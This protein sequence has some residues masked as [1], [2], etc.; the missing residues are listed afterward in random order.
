L[1][2][3]NNKYFT[4]IRN[5]EN[6]EVSNSTFFHYKQHGD[7]I[8]ADYNGGEIVKGHLLGLK[9]NDK[10]VFVYHHINT[11]K[12]IRTGECNS[13]LKINSAGRIELHEE[14]EWTNGDLSKGN[15]IIE[16]VDIAEIN[17]NTYNYS[18]MNYHNKFKDYS[19]Y[20]NQIEKFAAYLNKDDELLDFGCGS[21]LNAE[22]FTRYGIK[23]TGVDM[24]K[25]MID[26][27]EKYSP[28]SLFVHGDLR[29]YETS[30][31]FNGIAASFCIVHLT[32]NE[33]MEFLNKISEIMKDGAYLYLSFMEGKTEGF[34]KISFSDKPLYFNY[35]NR[36]EIQKELEEKGFV[37][38]EIDSE[39][40]HEDDGSVTKD[41]FMIFKYSFKK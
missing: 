23:V 35:Y 40:Y 9:K 15:S 10:L 41:I 20:T 16:E 37:L 38:I 21:G 19:V 25:S 36:H 27:A 24:S 30:Q 5:T 34:E 22:I 6:G 2:D 7:F 31:K 11:D 18:A 3:L 32:N 13:T 14:W 4:G 26:L 29:S 33:A 12:V 17:R 8:S 1:T 28:E 39:D